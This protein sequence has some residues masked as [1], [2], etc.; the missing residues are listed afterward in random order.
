LREALLDRATRTRLETIGNHP[1]PMSPSELL[2]FID[3]E[4]MAWKP[5][6]EEVARNP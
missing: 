6:L 5:M 1:N 2:A 4:Q 3:A